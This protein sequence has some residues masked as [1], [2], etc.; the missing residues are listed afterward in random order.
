MPR[1]AELLTERGHGG[2][3]SHS[4]VD[5]HAR[6]QG[7]ADGSTSLGLAEATYRWSP[8]TFHGDIRARSNGMIDER[9]IAVPQSQLCLGPRVSPL[10]APHTPV[11]VRAQGMG[12][13]LARGGHVHAPA[14]R[15]RTCVDNWAA[16]A[17]EHAC[18]T[19]RVL[20][21]HHPLHH[22][23]MR[24][25]VVYYRWWHK[26]MRPSAESHLVQHTR[27]IQ[28]PWHPTHP[29]ASFA[30]LSKRRLHRRTA[31]LMHVQVD[32]RVHVFGRAITV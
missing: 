29:S 19:P 5:P 13:R 7:C 18:R 3:S 2:G 23:S 32:K 25:G 15:V 24:T 4:A 20:W 27:G 8:E 11:V 10:A 31:G 1:T 17:K 6:V 9:S 12:D 22:V 30:Q 21:Q 14:R 26:I 28:L 16:I